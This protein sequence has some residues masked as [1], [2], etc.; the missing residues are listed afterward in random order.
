MKEGEVVLTAFE[1]ADGKT[2][3]SPAWAMLV[4]GFVVGIQSFLP[5]AWFC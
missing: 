1:Q 4:V 3:N 2:K 5:L